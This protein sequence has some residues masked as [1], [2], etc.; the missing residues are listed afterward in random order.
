MRSNLSLS[1]T[2]TIALSGIVGEAQVHKKLEQTEQTSFS[3][4]SG[5][6]KPVPLPS[7]FLELLKKDENALAAS[8]GCSNEGGG[9]G[10]LQASWFLASQ[11]HLAAAD[12]IDLV[13]LSTNQCLNGAHVGPFWVARK[14]M[15]GYQLILSTGGDGL[16]ILRDRSNGLRDIRRETFAAGRVSMTVY[17]F[18]GH[19]YG[20][21]S[22]D[23]K[24]IG[25]D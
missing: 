16:T 11:I 14:T 6:K 8:V 20:A 3:I 22:D 17:R 13:I 1:V 18:D 24:P 2:L 10:I 12:E 4:E 25:E 5:I 21:Y 9:P 7:E 15:N 23:S 19:K